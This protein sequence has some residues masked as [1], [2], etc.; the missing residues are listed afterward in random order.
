M[1]R[2]LGVRVSD[3]LYSA[4]GPFRSARAGLRNWRNRRF[5]TTGRGFA[6]ERAAHRAGAHLPVWRQ[7][8]N[9][10]TGR[11]RRDDPRIDRAGRAAARAV[12][13]RQAADRVLGPGTAARAAEAHRQANVNPWAARTV[14]VRAERQPLRIADPASGA[15][16]TFSVPA[17]HAK[18]FGDLMRG[19]GFTTGDGPEREAPNPRRSR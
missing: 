5:L 12:R 8:I 1:K 9:P 2:T 16:H 18:Q 4:G 15:E 6:V 3:W 13:M 17:E 19:L 7:R 11:Q 10:A 14:P